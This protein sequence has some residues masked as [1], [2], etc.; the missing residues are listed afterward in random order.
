ML[1]HTYVNFYIFI[2]INIT[3][4]FE[5]GT[6]TITDGKAHWLE[7][8]ERTKHEKFNNSLRVELHLH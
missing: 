2:F 4:Y 5:K 7:N 6:D 8:E 3:Y 1:I